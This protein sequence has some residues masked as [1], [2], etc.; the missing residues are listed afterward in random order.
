MK[1]LYIILLIFSF[2]LTVVGQRRAINKA[3]EF[4]ELNYFLESIKHY[5]DAESDKNIGDK[6]AYVTRRLAEANYGIFD[7]QKSLFWYNKLFKLRTKLSEDDY[8]NYASALRIGGDYEKAKEK[9]FQYANLVGD[10]KLKEYYK[11]L[12]DWSETS[13]KS[14]QIDVFNTNVN[15]GDRS[16][17]VGYY[18]EGLLFSQTK[19]NFKG[20]K[21]PFYDL[22]YSKTEGE[23]FNTSKELPG[24]ENNE[25]F[26]GGAF[27]GKKDSVLYFTSNASD[28]K[29]FRSLLDRYHL[30]KEGVNNLRIYST[31]FEDG[32]FQKRVDLNINDN[33]FSNAHPTLTENG[34]TLYFVSNREGGFG[35]YDIYRSIKTGISWSV[36]ENLGANINTDK[37]E[38]FPFLAN[39]KLYFSSYGHLNFGGSDIFESIIHK[40]GSVSKPENMG[41][42]YNSSMDDFGMIMNPATADGYLSSNRNDTSG[43]DHIYYFKKAPNDIVIANAKQRFNLNPIDS[44]TV[45]LYQVI[46]DDE[47]LVENLFT[48]TLG[49]TEFSLEKGKEY[50][51]YFMK[52]GYKPD[53]IAKVISKTDRKNIVALFDSAPIPG[54]P[55]E[56]KNIYFAFDKWDILEES[57][58][59]LDQLFYYMQQ[60]SKVDVFIGA[61]TDCRGTDLYNYKLSDKRAESAIE[62]LIQKGVHPDRLS[63]KGYGKSQIKVICGKCSKCTE[64]QHQQNR[65]V[66]FEIKMPTKEENAK[67]NTDKTLYQ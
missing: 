7:Y 19:K 30:S 38:M 2:S 36:P 61:H 54:K 37:N 65:R 20:T 60:Y 3:D 32:E 48:D 31:K 64:E 47:K 39:G 18:K 63:W 14:A 55:M 34:D 25:F 59:V 23:R 49:V 66:T 40:D 16:L 53:T 52:E 62:Y 44:V 10:D 50:V 28:R 58:P 1:R 9:F 57:K 56:I 45:D 11:N 35:G 43:Y 27:F 21:T 41:K 6:K 51:A 8:Y 42:P 29:K 13:E 17:G 24:F 26:N 46:G 12:S 15:T 67:E 5:E 22:V 33:D 4:F